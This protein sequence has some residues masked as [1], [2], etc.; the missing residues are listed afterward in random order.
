MK[1][2]PDTLKIFS[3][4]IKKII[5]AL[6]LRAFSLILFFILIDL[7]FGGFI[8]YKYVFLAQK[9]EPKAAENILKFDKKSYQGVLSELQARE[10]AAEPPPAE[11]QPSPAEQPQNNLAK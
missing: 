8:F 10:Q 4:K 3:E 9:E 1:N 5:W 2:T 11:S 7:I 6:G